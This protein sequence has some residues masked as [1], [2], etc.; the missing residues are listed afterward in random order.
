MTQAAKTPLSPYQWKLFAFLSV[1]CLF[2]GYDFFAL[3]QI[4]PNL[5][6]NFALSEGAGGLLVA[7]INVGTIIAF[8]LIRQTDRWGRRRMLMITIAGYTLMSLMTGLAWD[9][10]SFGIFQMVARIFL[11]AEW[12]ITM[13]YAAE[14]FPA[15]RRGL[16]IGVIQAM[17]SVGAV[18]CAGIVPLLLK[19]E[20]GWRMVYFIGVIPLIFIMIWRRGLKETRRFEEQG[21]AA[22]ARESSFLDVWRTPARRR[23]IQMGIIW[24]LTYLCT[25]SAVTFWKEFAIAERGM[26]DGDVGLAIT[27][28]AIGSM[29]LI[30]MAGKLLDVVGRRI[31]ATI[32]FLSCAFSV[33]AMYTL[34]TWA[35]LT[36]MI[37]L[38]IF[39]VS[40]VLPVLNTY[41]TE[42]FP[43]RVRSDAFA[44][45]NNIL[46]RVGYVLAPLIVGSMA[47]TWGWGPSVSVTALGPLIA[48]ALILLWLPETKGREL[49]EIAGA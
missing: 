28:G 21:V 22:A 1:A 7:V 36:A 11:I 23:I 14:E 40:A 26:T 15:D 48:L 32:I 9:V 29:P 46:G 4:L 17:N 37:V 19:T 43:T 24:T 5:R 12:A 2:E 13:V 49:E 8:L 27:I 16:A 25:Q 10:W 39:G 6:A 20:L 31:G 47:Q 45:S 33:V 44:W 34:E 3:A 41:N 38:G 35:S 18:A 42:L 30:F